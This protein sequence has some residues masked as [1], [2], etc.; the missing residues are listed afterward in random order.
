LH[1]A[2]RL[3][4][5]LRVSQYVLIAEFDPQQTA[6]YRQSVERHGIEPVLV[7]DGTAAARVLQ[8]RGA[9]I[10]LI[11]DLSLPQADGFSVIAELRR[12]SPPEQSAILVFSAH[13]A[14]RAAALNLRS[15]LGIAEVADKNQP[16]ESIVDAIGRTLDRVAQAP[17]YTR[18]SAREDE[19]LH[20][21]MF[22][23]AKAFRSPMVVLSIELRDR[24]RIAGHLNIDEPPGSSYFWPVLQQVTSTREPLVIPDITKHSLFGIGLQPPALGVRAF[25]TIPLITSAGRL[26]GAMSVIDL[27]PQTLTA[28]QLDLL[29]RAGHRIADELANYYRDELAETDDANGW[30]SRERWAALERLALTDRV[31]GLFNR[32]AGELA[33]E[34]EVARARRTRAPFSLVLIDVDH[35]KQVNDRHGHAAGDEVLKQVSTI[36]TSTFRA[37]DLAVRWGGDEFLVFL[38]DVTVGGAMV[39]A[40]RARSQVEALSF[41]SIGQVTLSA[42]IAQ[43]RPDEDARAAIRRADAQLYEAKRSGRNLIKVAPTSS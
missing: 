18:S 14:L 32:H 42:G 39:F 40:E 10:L 24:N 8:S 22:R 13:T 4:T 28:L 12:L 16:P 23:T 27:Q 19:L 11:C 34:R 36:L 29:L 35:F 15:T 20:K 7:R 31:T 38:P 2:G 37:S 9:P 25:A 1:E 41:D 6:I 17:Q 3:P 26:V 5:G 33:L 30:R 21:I 43:V